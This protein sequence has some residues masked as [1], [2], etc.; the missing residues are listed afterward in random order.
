MNVDDTR[1]LVV[2]PL[3]PYGLDIWNL[4][5]LLLLLPWFREGSSTISYCNISIL[6]VSCVE[7][8]FRMPGIGEHTYMP[9][10]HN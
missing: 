6:I 1:L 7:K 2:R 5:V 10:P 4:G 9:Y 8:C 3:V